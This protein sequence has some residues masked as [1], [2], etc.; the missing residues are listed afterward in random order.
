MGFSDAKSIETES[1][2]VT[3][4]DGLYDTEYDRVLWVARI[5]GSG[6]TVEPATEYET[7]EQVGWP[8]GGRSRVITAGTTFAVTEFVDLIDTGRFE[9]APL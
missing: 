3:P 5:D 4:G 2:T 6:V 7:E 8:L 1:A 9:V